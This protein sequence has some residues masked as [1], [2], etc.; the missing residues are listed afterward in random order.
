[1]GWG[2]LRAGFGGQGESEG[3]VLQRDVP[4]FRH[5]GERCALSRLLLCSLGLVARLDEEQ[6]G[7]AGEDERAAGDSG[8]DLELASPRP[9]L[10]FALGLLGVPRRGDECLA[11]Q[12]DMEIAAASRF[13]GACQSRASPKFGRLVST[14]F[15]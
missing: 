2:S 14:R 12:I 1:M 3:R 4:G 7:D 11:C 13:D 8:G 15:P 5:E 9:F 10:P 6:D